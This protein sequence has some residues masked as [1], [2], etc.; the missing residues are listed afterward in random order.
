MRAMGIVRT[1]PRRAASASTPRAAAE[2]P[3][4]GY[5][6]EAV[7]AGRAV[8]AEVAVSADGEVSVVELPTSAPD[9]LAERV[10]LLVR[11]AYKH[12][13]EDGQPPAAAPPPLARRALTGGAPGTGLAPRP[14]A[15][16][17]PPHAASGPRLS[18]LVHAGAGHV[19]RR[20]RR[21]SSDATWSRPRPPSATPRTPSARTTPRWRSS[22]RTTGSRRRRCCARSSAS[23]ATRSTRASPSFASPTPTT[24]R[25][26]S[27]TRSASTRTSS[28]PTGPT[29]TT[30]RTRGRG[31]PRATYAEIPE[32]FL[33]AASEERDQ[34]AVVD[35]YKELGRFLADY[36]NAKETPHVRELLAQIIA[37]LVRHELYVARF[38][39]EQGQLRR[40]GRA[41][42]VRAEEVPGGRRQRSG[43]P[44][45]T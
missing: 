22:T 32:S 38:Y 25:R 28:T 18:A 36:P 44:A 16:T 4:L 26:S 29:R 34:A 21:R 10:R 13:R 12:A 3:A 35:A 2:G 14:A 43:A 1:V 42:P 31:S 23:T 37:R 45:K 11:A 30:S 9:G 27:P 8:S 41:H 39:L 5:E 20:G 24:S 33:M 19:V 17:V 15:G 6:G 40:R 7:D